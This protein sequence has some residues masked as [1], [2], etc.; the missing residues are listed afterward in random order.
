M[1]SLRPPPRRGSVRRAEFAGRCE[2]GLQ[3]SGDVLGPVP[4]ESAVADEGRAPSLVAP[5]GQ[6]SEWNAEVLGHLV[7]LEQGDELVPGSG[8]WADRPPG[9]LGHP[10]AVHRAGGHDSQASLSSG[11][12]VPRRGTCKGVFTG[13]V[14]LD[15]VGSGRGLRLRG[16]R[17]SARDGGMPGRVEARGLVL[18]GRWDGVIVHDLQGLLTALNLSNPVERKR[19]RKRER[20]SIAP[21]VPLSS[22]S[23]VNKRR[24]AGGDP[25]CR[26]SALP[27]VAW[28]VFPRGLQRVTSLSYC[29]AGLSAASRAADSDRG[30]VA[31]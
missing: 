27:P 6:R 16:G 30:S 13:G 21:R 3:P 7:G 10:R 1:V 25:Q 23:V 8:C 11:G 19:K 12:Q 20:K 17:W 31:W 22:R 26:R 29:D 5:V 15:E 4:N 24:R 18:A 9:F 28:P 2:V 14:A